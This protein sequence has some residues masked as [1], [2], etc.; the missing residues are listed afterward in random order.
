M[1]Q[2]EKVVSAAEARDRADLK[3]ILGRFLERLQ[4]GEA[5]EAEVRAALDELKSKKK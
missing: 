2:G 3:I 5:V 1:S 4:N